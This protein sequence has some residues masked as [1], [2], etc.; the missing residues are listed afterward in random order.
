M[1]QRALERAPHARLGERLHG[2]HDQEPAIGAE[3]RTTAQVHE[4]AGPA[5]AARVVGALDGAEQIRVSGRRFENDRR[6]IFVVVR[7]NHVHAVH[8]E[9]IAVRAGR[10]HSTLARFLAFFALSGTNGIDKET[11]RLDEARN[12]KQQLALTSG[13][14]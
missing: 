7:Q 2:V 10:F 1:I 12:G 3:Q 9:R 8:A 13:M 6:G 4:I 5:A 11:A 14:T